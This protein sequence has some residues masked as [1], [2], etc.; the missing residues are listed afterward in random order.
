MSEE[1]PKNCIGYYLFVRQ[2]IFVDFSWK[3]KI[4]EINSLINNKL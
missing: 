2:N 1:T 3:K 4:V